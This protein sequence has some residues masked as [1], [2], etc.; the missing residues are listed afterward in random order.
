[1]NDPMKCPKCQFENPDDTVYCGKCGTKF[2]ASEDLPISRTETIQAPIRELTTGT[3]FAGRYQVIEEIGKGGMGKVYKVLDK[4]IDGKV[5][6]KLIRPEIVTDK[7]TIERFRNELK[8]AR[9]ISHKNV[10]RMYDLNKDEETYYITME[11]VPGEDLKSF[12]RRAGQLSVGKSIAIAKQ[13]CEGLVEAHRLEVVHRDL[14]P[15]NVMIDREGNV[16]IMDFGVARSLKEK[17]ITGVGVMIGTPEYMSPEQV[18][19]KEVDQRSDIYSL[20][21]IIYEMVTGRVPFEGDTPLSIAVKHKIEAPRSPKEINAQI[22]DDLS[23]V[24]LKCM[25]KDKEKRCQSAS[26]LLS[27]LANIEKGIP[28]T[29]RLIPKRKPITSREITVKFKLKKLFIPALVVIALAVIWVIVWQL[30][31]QKEAIPVLSD[32]PSIAVISFNNQ[33]GDKAYDYL[34]DAIPNLLITSLEQS[35]YLSVTTWERMYDLLKQMGK[36][37]P[38]VI[39]RDLGFELCRMDGVDAIVLGSFIKAG[40]LFATDVKVLD[41]ESKSL[42]KSASSKGEGVR[43]ILESQIDELSKEIALG[44]G[45]SERKI[46]A[47]QLRI[48][49]VTTT[50]MDAFNLFLRGREDQEKLYYDDARR[51][52]EKAVE[53]DPSFALAYRYLASVYYGL[54]N[55]TERDEAIKKAKASSKK[56]SDKERLYIEAA[57]AI[58]IEKDREKSFGILKEMVKKYPKEKRVHYDLAM[59]YRNKGLPDK[60]IEEFN[61][62]MELD[63][64]YGYAIND[65]AYTYAFIGNLEKAIEYFKRYASVSPGN[66]NPLDSMAEMYLRMGELDEAI[67]KYKVAL[68]IK[69]DFGSDWNI[70]YI[71]ALKE[72]YHEVMK[73]IDQFIARAPSPGK[74]AEGLIWKGFYHYWLGSL[75]QSLSQLR[76]AEEMA[77]AVGNELWKSYVNWVR[78]WFFYDQGEHERSQRHF[79][80][81]NDIN[82]A[83]FPSLIPFYQAYYSFYLGLIDLKQG[84]IDSAKSRL[85]EVKSQLPK[86]GS[87]TK[88]RLKFRYDFLSAEVLLAE[89]SFDRAISVWE[90][91]SPLGMTR[92]MFTWYIL[93]YNAPFLKDVLA[94]AY[95]KKGEIDKAITE[96]ER[97]ITFDSQSPERFLIHPKYHYRLA[98][99]YEEKGWEG[100]AIEEYQKFLDL[101]KNADPDIP[102][103]IDAKK[104]LASLQK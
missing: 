92:S 46:K 101:W 14:K 93:T 39:D 95:R 64:K 62:A 75:E 19:G 43:S 37:K 103:V 74:K 68:E 16:R 89:D 90:K 2:Q 18:E 36:E 49:E 5:A 81:W 48:S 85:A 29:E 86:V 47:T 42:L 77:E 3:T 71:Y 94:R 35:G 45:L 79:K 15:Q 98:I 87:S 70:A 26:E 22:P 65:L 88:V 28:T 9:D 76:R 52:L 41:V 21:V 7:K 31:P 67:A 66:A 83:N 80:S 34:R 78:G 44:V 32:K 38:E 12:I 56:A 91:T 50:S 69:P 51:F 57:Y 24:V 4:E 25:E 102:E 40:D 27:E 59:L 72:E 10:C 97:L 6:L 13:V 33:T 23:R 60:A 30:L 100:K 11:Y 63:P 104:Q 96:Y 8:M 84:K 61:K 73:W 54:G 17:G 58:T 53:I 55:L 82:T 99:L 1:M 20:G